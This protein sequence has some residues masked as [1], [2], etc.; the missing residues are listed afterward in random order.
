MLLDITSEEIPINSMEDFFTLLK[1]TAEPFTLSASGVLVERM[2]AVY[3]Y[4]GFHSRTT[5]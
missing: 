4:L 2:N 5:S 3:E 1:A